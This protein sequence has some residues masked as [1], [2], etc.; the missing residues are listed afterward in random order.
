MTFNTPQIEASMLEWTQEIV[1][2]LCNAWINTSQVWQIILQVI[3]GLYKTVD[4]WSVNWGLEDY[5]DRWFELDVA[6][7]NW[8]FFSQKGFANVQ[9][10][11]PH[12]FFSAHLAQFANGSAN[13]ELVSYIRC[14]RPDVSGYL[15][16]TSGCLIWY[17]L[18]S[19]LNNKQQA[20]IFVATLNGLY[21]SFIMLTCL[22]NV[23]PLPYTVTPHF[24]IAKL[25]LMP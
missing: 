11:G 25:V 1:P 19:L 4:N 7:F 9:I 22:C 6:F 18:T 24:Y 5:K 16:R 17:D 3:S 13:P 2:I 10:I 8:F 14:E 21:L 12:L 23:H 15:I 20:S